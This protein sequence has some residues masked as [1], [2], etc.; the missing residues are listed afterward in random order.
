[1]ALVGMIALLAGCCVAKTDRPGVKALLWSD[2]KAL[3]CEQADSLAQSALELLQ[4][5]DE[6]A[7]LIVSPDLIDSIRSSGTALEIIWPETLAFNLPSGA[8]DILGRVIIPLKGE[9]ASDG[10]GALIFFGTKSYGTPALL[11]HA[12]AEKL[13]RIE[14]LLENENMN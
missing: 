3:P 4:S 12:A 1:M 14:A 2:G 11:N 7:R 13:A 9:Y 10:A 8:K 5:A 6:E